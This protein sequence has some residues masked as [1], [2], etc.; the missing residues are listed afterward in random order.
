MESFGYRIFALWN[1]STNGLTISRE[2]REEIN[3]ERCNVCGTARD[4][5]K[6]KSL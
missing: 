4:R 3:N 1:I 6:S 5:N 2:N